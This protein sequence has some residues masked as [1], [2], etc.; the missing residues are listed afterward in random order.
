M[1][2]KAWSLLGKGSEG[3][4]YERGTKGRDKVKK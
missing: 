1:A 3:G 4:C 2:I